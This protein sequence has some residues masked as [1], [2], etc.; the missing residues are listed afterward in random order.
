MTV[1]PSNNGNAPYPHVFSVIVTY[2]DRYHLLQQVIDATISNGA[3]KVIIVDN[4]STSSTRH[5][6]QKLEQQSN[7]RITTL[8]LGEN[9]GSAGGFKA[10]LEYAMTC[11]DC[12][13]LWL[14]DDDNQPAEGA[15][16]EL[17]RQYTRL[18]VSS[19]LD[20][21]ALVAF[22]E[23]QD[24]YK[25]IARGVPLNKVFARESSFMGFHLLDQPRKFSEFF[26]LKRA[27]PQ[28]AAGESP[29]EVPFAPYGGLF[30]HKSVIAK[31]GYP[32]EHFFI[33]CDDI[34]F[35]H[36]L[37]RTGGRLFLIPASIIRDLQPSWHVRKKGETFFEHLLTSGSDS[38]IYFT[39]RNQTYL[40][41]HLWMR[42]LIVYTVNKWFFF[43][44][45]ALFSLRYGETRRIAL[46][47]KAAKH[48]E[49]GKLGRLANF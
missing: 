21:L 9:R 32:N 24:Y 40:E 36:R 22:R 25:K 2:G 35:T 49:A 10:G 39:A 18:S 1:T 46:I 17:L 12:E 16:T 47:A 48:G 4:A 20:H 34:E 3:E 30:F 14:L 15:L 41:R 38:R 26:Q 27:V 45:L 37:T 29:I 23:D 6:I 7:G 44:L 28:Q 8:I 5:A 43:L 42:N 19:E 33:Y 13:Y 11:S 31:V